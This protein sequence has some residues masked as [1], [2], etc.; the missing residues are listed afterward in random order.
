MGQRIWD[1]PFESTLRT[2]QNKAWTL[3]AG[4][5]MMMGVPST[6]P[7]DRVINHG[8]KEVPIL[9]TLHHGIWT[10]MPQLGWRVGAGH[11]WLREEPIW[12]DRWSVS[13]HLSQVRQQESFIGSVKGV[14]VDTSLVIIENPLLTEASAMAL[15][16]DVQSARGLSAGPEGF[17][18]W[19]VGV[20]GAFHLGQTGAPVLPMFFAPLTLPQWHVAFVVGLGAGLKIYRGRMVRLTVDVDA[21]QLVQGQQ[22]QTTRATDADVR[23]LNWMQSGYRPWRLTL[24]HDL[25]RRK[26]D[27]GCAAPTHSKAS[28][29]LFD[30]KTMKGVG[31]AKHRGLKKAL[32]NRGD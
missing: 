7:S 12:A 30:P 9:D 4:T 8:S 14:G 16:F 31:K 1:N 29:T 24:H 23:G 17:L 28:K 11:L 27:A 2:H 10:T 15:D 19:R 13:M 32:K 3:S 26:P 5:A 21:L 20:R 22:P 25:Y 18:E 6:L